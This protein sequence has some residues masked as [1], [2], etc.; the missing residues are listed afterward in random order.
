L[1]I[2]QIQ[3]LGEWFRH[4]SQKV[5]QPTSGNPL[6]PSRL[7][8]EALLPPRKPRFDYIYSALFYQ[9]HVKHIYEASRQILVDCEIEFE[10][11]ALRNKITR[12]IY[13]WEPVDVIEAV[14]IEVDAQYANAK[15]E[16]AEFQEEMP[17]GDQLNQ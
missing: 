16:F 7:L 3:R 17:S 10:D 11:I 5:L 14:K 2:K 8:D 1:L 9:D 13:K 15:R 12:E 4:H 6:V